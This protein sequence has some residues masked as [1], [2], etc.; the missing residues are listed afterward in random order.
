LACSRVGNGSAPPAPKCAAVRTNGRNPRLLLLVRVE[1]GDHRDPGFRKS[2][3]SSIQIHA[4]P[5]A[6]NL[7]PFCVDQ[8]VWSF[9]VVKVCRM[10]RTELSD[11]WVVAGDVASLQTSL[12]AFFKKHKMWGIG[13]QAGEM[14]VRQGS[15]LL[16]RL[17]GCWL[18]RSRW[19]PKRAIVKLDR[20][21]H[22]VKIRANIE[23]SI[24]SRV[25]SPFLVKK[26]H[27]YFGRWMA[28]LKA[29]VQ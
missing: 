20:A 1:H 22:G 4:P 17:F 27:T 8:V 24:A 28:D 16:T 11:S 15:A 10:A 25:M 23:E 18:S 6:F 12:K 9:T 26:Y 21:D 7:L 19:L 14:H 5:P 3:I 29:S 13:E 2:L